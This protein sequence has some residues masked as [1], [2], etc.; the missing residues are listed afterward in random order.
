[1]SQSNIQD[2]KDHSANEA[3]NWAGGDERGAAADDITGAV[4]V[5]PEPPVTGQADPAVGVVQR[6]DTT[7]LQQAWRV[8]I[9]TRQRTIRI[10]P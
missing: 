9:R 6:R 4:P 3:D 10:S 7:F 1:M 5:S 2:L 8:P